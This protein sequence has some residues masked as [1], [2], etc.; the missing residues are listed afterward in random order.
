MKTIEEVKAKFQ[1]A[2]VAENTF[3]GQTTLQVKK[4]SLIEL[5]SFLKGVPGF[6]NLTDLT[7]CRLC[8]RDKS[9]LFSSESDNI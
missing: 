4:E 8:D 2:L 3:S 1:Q 9:D 5:L 7:V 6:T